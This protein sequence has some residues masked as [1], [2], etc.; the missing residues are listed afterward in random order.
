MNK[1]DEVMIREA[2]IHGQACGMLLAMHEGFHPHPER[3]AKWVE[4]YK[5]MDRMRDEALAFR[6]MD[7]TL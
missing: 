4:D 5:A 6:L 7:I 1:R 3:L 2:N